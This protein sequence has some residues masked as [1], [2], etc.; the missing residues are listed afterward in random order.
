MSTKSGKVSTSEVARKGTLHKNCKLCSLLNDY[1]EL[2]K[3]THKKVLEDGLPRAKV[4]RWLNS[5]LE[6]INIDLADVDKIV[7]FSGENFSRHFHNHIPNYEQTKIILRDKALGRT[8]DSD[9]TDF[10]VASVAVFEEFV[11]T[12]AEEQSDYS[13]ITKMISTLEDHMVAYNTYLV[14][15]S[16]VTRAQVGKRP[17]HLSE[18]SEFKS[19][20]ES[21]T[22]LKLKVA[23]IRN[24][25]AV[26]GAAVRRA[27]K[28]S[29]ELF[30]NHMV[31]ATD[32]A[33]QSLKE[34]LPDSTL[35]TEVIDKARHR[36]AN[37]IKTS[38]PG[39]IEKIY[40]EYGIK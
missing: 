16:A 39:V 14:E 40:S 26:S 5:K 21:L 22:D 18:L 10:P 8:R 24:S 4:C 27:M 37:N 6:I 33:E 19:L 28:L 17:I 20:V 9:I 12:Y 2:W 34:V 23:K 35:P 1:P 36:M 32:E 31:L 7:D 15:K 3:E 13:S 38:L 29:V 30:L 11:E 25:S